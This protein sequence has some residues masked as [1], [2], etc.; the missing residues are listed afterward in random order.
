MINDAARSV[1]ATER[2]DRETHE[3]EG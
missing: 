2:T 3:R 1:S